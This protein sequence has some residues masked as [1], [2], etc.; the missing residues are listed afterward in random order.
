MNTVVWKRPAAFRGPSKRLETRPPLSPTVGPTGTA[1]WVD[2]WLAVPGLLRKCC[3]RP[4]SVLC[5]TS[6]KVT[7]AFSVA[8]LSNQLEADHSFAE[9]V[10]IEQASTVTL[11]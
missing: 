9:V 7:A 5:C 3:I 6:S 8:A 10:L 1:H 11:C 4:S 2:G